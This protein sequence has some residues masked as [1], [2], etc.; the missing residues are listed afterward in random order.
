M[1]HLVVFAHPNPNSF[2]QSICDNVVSLSKELGNNVEVRNLYKMNF[3]PVLSPSDFSSIQKGKVPADIKT[4]Q[5]HVAEADLITLI[6]PL[7]W[8]GYPA[9]L[10]GWIDRVLLNDFAY[11]YEPKTGAVPLL[12]GK[13]VQILTTMGQ[14][15]EEYEAN[16]LMDAMAMTMGDNVW[17]FCGCEDA[18]MIVLGEIPG[19][20]EKDRQEVLDEIRE[21]LI[22]ALS[23][24]SQKSGKKSSTAKTGTKASS[25]PISTKTS[26]SPVKKTKPAAKKPTRKK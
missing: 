6:F 20:K 13:R 4:E 24:I 23:D 18:G 9:I 5:E 16:G 7:W 12:T 11:K 17:S 3:N 2:C 8:T 22:I 10:K 25:K 15:V 19:M 26:K 1:R 21:T 14:S